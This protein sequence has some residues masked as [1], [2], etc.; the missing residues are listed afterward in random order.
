MSNFC[1]TNAHHCVVLLCTKLGI[2]LPNLAISLTC[3]IV[4]HFNNLTLALDDVNR[5][6][7]AVGEGPDLLGALILAHVIGYG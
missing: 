1:K 2:R 4:G 7:F 5:F 3:S 6:S